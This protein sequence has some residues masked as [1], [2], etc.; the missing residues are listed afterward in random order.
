[1]NIIGKMN[2]VN[3]IVKTVSHKAKYYSPLIAYLFQT[4]NKQIELY[5]DTPTKQNFPKRIAGKI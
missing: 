3:I 5:E 2:Y 4:G 1:M